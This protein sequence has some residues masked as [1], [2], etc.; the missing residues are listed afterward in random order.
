MRRSRWLLVT[1]MAA[2]LAVP[3][4]GLA[5]PVRDRHQAH[6]GTSA[7]R[8]ADDGVDPHLNHD[9]EDHPGTYIPSPEGNSS[10]MHLL[11]S[12]ERA[13]TI[14][15]Y[16]NSDLAFWGSYAFAGNYEGFRVIDIANPLRPRVLSDF[17]C[18]ASQHDVSVWHG[19]LFL[20]VDT[21]RTGPGCDSE[22]IADPGVGWEGIRIFDVRNPR[23]PR[24][25][26]GVA[27]DCGSHTHTLVPTGRQDLVLIYVASYPAARFGPTPYG[28]TCE[29]LADDGSQGHSRIS[30]VEVPLRAPAT[31]RVV[32]KPTFEL[33]DRGGVP[34]F[35]GCHD[36]AVFS[37]LQRAAAACM[38]EGQIWD[39]S[40][41][42]RPR[43]I[44]RIHN[45]SIDFWHSSTFTWDGRLVLFGDE[46]GGGTQPRCRTEDPASLGALWIYQL[47]SLDVT[48]GATVEPWLG[49]FKID[50]V[51]DAGNCTTHNFN[52]IPVRGRYVGISG[53]YAGGTSVIDF[54][55]PSRPH[56]AG[57]F[58]PHGA[59][60]WSAYW[61]N[62]IIYTNDTG[63]GVDTM[64]LADRRRLGARALPYL[65]PQT[66][67]RRLR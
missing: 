54:T 44:A 64:Y 66:Q 9:G 45:P 2:T 4:T 55:D 42:L 35:R 5:D 57:Y 24:F 56:E 31:A 53:Y 67:E 60:T 34:G 14:A 7:A 3:S 59:N 13:G 23:A 19:F 1:V 65:N 38:S 32:A 15:G 16:R 49:T 18:P 8:A 17:A 43:T 62:G 26:T 11:A 39:I 51:Q 29:Q 30:V 20:S 52:V 46:A 22:A 58:D 41:P 47:S 61:Y 6:L 21:P 40:D 25:V 48:D 10:N 12:A 36:I 63:R 28:T 50:R 37:E 33:N 27:T